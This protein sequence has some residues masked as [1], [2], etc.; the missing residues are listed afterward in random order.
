[1]SQNH[2]TLRFPLKSPGDAARVADHLPPLMP[3]LFQAADPVGTVHYARFTVLSDRTLLFLVGPALMVTSVVLACGL[4][5]TGLSD[6]PSLR[7]FGWVSALAMMA[8]LVADLLILRPTITLLQRWEG[9]LPRRLTGF[10][11]RR[12]P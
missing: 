7:L 11:G 5:V 1:M 6:L 8:A 10:T 3:S 12:V 4:G 9:R 2:F